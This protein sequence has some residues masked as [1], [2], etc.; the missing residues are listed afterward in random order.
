M[1]IQETTPTP[2]HTD[3][4]EQLRPIAEQL[5]LETRIAAEK[6]VAHISAPRTYPLPQRGDEPTLEHVLVQRLQALPASNRQRAADQLMP[7]VRA[8]AANRAKQ[9]G[10]LAKVDLCSTT[11]IAVQAARLDTDLTLSAEALLA[12]AG[13]TTTSVASQSPPKGS[14]TALSA[15]PTFKTLQVRLRTVK[16]WDETDGEW[17]GSDTILLGGIAHEPD[18]G[19]VRIAPFHV[20][21]T[22]DAPGFDD[23]EVVDYNPPK[24]LASFDLAADNTF[25]DKNKTLPVTWPRTYGYTFLLAEEDHGGFSGFVTNLY[26][27]VQVKAQEKIVKLVKDGITK[28]TGEKFGDVVGKIVQDVTGKVLADI[29]KLLKDVEADDIFPPVN[30]TITLPHRTRDFNGVPM[31]PKRTRNPNRLVISGHGGVYHVYFAWQLVA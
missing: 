17:P 20:K 2:Q 31:G 13:A 24:V 14:A 8:D 29:L 16:C 21:H 19:T 6:A 7:S 1:A 27:A 28:E 10:E 22:K 18:G 4:P 30:Q 25:V 26:Q 11:P 3:L 15:A 5:L 9:Y 23:D 12:S